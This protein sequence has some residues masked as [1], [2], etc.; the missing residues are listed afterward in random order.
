MGICK[1][2]GLTQYG[3]YEQSSEEINRKPVYWRPLISK[4]RH[5]MQPL[6]TP[7]KDDIALDE[8]SLN[9]AST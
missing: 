3:V 8:L 4:T 5:G 7:K 9:T 2:F 6:K 1:I